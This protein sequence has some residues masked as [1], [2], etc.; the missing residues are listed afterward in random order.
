MKNSHGCFVVK[1]GWMK[2]L[3]DTTLTTGSYMRQ[4]GEQ[5]FDHEARLF[6]TCAKQFDE[7]NKEVREPTAFPVQTQAH[8]DIYLALPVSARS[9]ARRRRQTVAKSLWG[10]WLGLHAEGCI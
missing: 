5:E 6:T 4:S 8:S 2:E 9:I 3:S 10:Q 1:N 7:L